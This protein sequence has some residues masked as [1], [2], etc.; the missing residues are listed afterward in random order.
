MGAGDGIIIAL[1]AP[2]LYSVLS[3]GWA[4]LRA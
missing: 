1:L 4:G 3:A 2:M